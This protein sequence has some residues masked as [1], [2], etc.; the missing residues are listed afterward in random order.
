ML[1]DREVRNRLNYSIWIILITNCGKF[2]L[3]ESTINQ[4]T[5]VIFNLA[6]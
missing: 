3:S 5:D 2:L 1:S 6:N 4:R